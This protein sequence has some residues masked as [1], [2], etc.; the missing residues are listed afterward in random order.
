[1]GNIQKFVEGTSHAKTKNAHCPL[2]TF[3]TAGSN[4][5]SVNWIRLTFL[6]LLESNRKKLKQPTKSSTFMK[7]NTIHEY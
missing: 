2:Q 5:L 7:N 4:I 6:F 3:S 1:M